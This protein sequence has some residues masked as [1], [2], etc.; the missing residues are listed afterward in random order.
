[1][2]PF[3]VVLFWLWPAAGCGCRPA[4]HR[5]LDAAGILKAG[6]ICTTSA[7]CCHHPVNAWIDV[8]SNYGFIEAKTQ[9]HFA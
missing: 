8:R 7:D 2:V 4:S 6:P 3:E 9:F 5:R 1:L